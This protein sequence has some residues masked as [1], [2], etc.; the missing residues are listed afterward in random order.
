MRHS[1]IKKRLLDGSPCRKCVQ[2]EEMIRGRGLWDKIDEVIWAV[3]GQPDSPGMQLATRHGID[4]APF[5]ITRSPSG[6]ERV[7][8]STVEFVK[9]LAGVSQLGLAFGGAE[10]VALIDMAAKTGVRF[11][12]FCLDTGRLHPET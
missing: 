9:E 1:M 10:D 3:E 6:E 2:A 7:Y 5:F 12:V 4:T 11:S 8:T